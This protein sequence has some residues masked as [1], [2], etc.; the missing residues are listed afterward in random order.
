[1]LH[2][3]AVD[4]DP[5][6]ILLPGYFKQDDASPHCSSVAHEY[7]GL[8]FPGRWIGRYI[9]LEWPCNPPDLMPCSFSCGA[10]QKS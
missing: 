9:P 10:W 2:S 5:L 4:G 1:M 7:L 6:L 8:V 3:Y